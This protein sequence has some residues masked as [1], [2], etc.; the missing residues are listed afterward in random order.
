MDQ[1]LT[2]RGSFENA[3]ADV[4][5]REVT[6]AV[7][8][9]RAKLGDLGAND[10]VSDAEILTLILRA[11]QNALLRTDGPGLQDAFKGL[12]TNPSCAIF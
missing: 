6:I 1:N 5:V 4:P 11:G 3:L 8:N 7:R 2:A 10:G 9:V 12:K